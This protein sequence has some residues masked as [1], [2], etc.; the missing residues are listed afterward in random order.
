MP[1]GGVQQRDLGTDNDSNWRVSKVRR[2][3]H[4]MDKDGRTDGQSSLL[5]FERM[6]KVSIE[7]TCMLRVSS[8]GTKR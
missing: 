7:S 4:S 2:D 5:I 8:K 6:E 1:F 3:I